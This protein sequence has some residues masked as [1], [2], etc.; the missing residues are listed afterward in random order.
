MTIGHHVKFRSITTGHLV[1][2]NPIIKGLCSS[3]RRGGGGKDMSKFKIGFD[4][5]KKFTHEINSKE[6]GGFIAKSV[7]KR[8]VALQQN[9]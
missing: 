6:N 4:L 5:K 9:L 1:N 8:M 7:L 2:F 3:S